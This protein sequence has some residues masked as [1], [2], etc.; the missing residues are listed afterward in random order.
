MF[1]IDKK[2]FVSYTIVA[3]WSLTMFDFD[4]INK[5]WAG[6]AHG[7]L[8]GNKHDGTQAIIDSK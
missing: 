6:I 3:G 1:I 2:Q 5:E 8:Y 4:R 7:T